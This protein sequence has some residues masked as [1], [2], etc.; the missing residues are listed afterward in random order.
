MEICFT[1]WDG[2]L[3]LCLEK[4]KSASQEKYSLIGREKHELFSFYIFLCNDIALD[5]LLN[6]FHYTVLIK[7]T[8]QRT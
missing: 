2:Q 7:W 8:G 6:Y 4:E 3:P 5:R 1:H